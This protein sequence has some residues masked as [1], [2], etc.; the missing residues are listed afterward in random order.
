MGFPLTCRLL[1]P[2]ELRLTRDE[3]S[4]PRCMKR[5]SRTNPNLC[6]LLSTDC[7]NGTVELSC[8]LGRTGD[9][10]RDTEV[11]SFSVPDRTSLRFRRT[12][13]RGGGEGSIVR[14]DGV[15]GNHVIAGAENC[16]AR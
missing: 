12:G 11:G 15:G 10:L 8:V 16:V 3:M 4:L 9:A 14:K 1:E 6:V 7:V 2:V 5:P 13:D